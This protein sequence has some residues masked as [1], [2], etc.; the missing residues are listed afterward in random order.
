M[1]A[2]T[3]SRTLP[4]TIDEKRPADAPTV[5]GRPFAFALLS[6]LA[7][8]AC[9]AP[10]VEV[11]LPLGVVSFSPQDGASNVCP[12]WP[13][14]VCFNQPIDP[15]AMTNGDLLLGPASCAPRAAIDGGVVSGVS[16]SVAESDD[17]G[18]PICVTLTPSGGL[19]PGSCYALEAEGADVTQTPVV[20]ADGGDPLAVTV[21]SIF[22][23]GGPQSCFSADAG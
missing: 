11:S 8:F 20:S 16:A 17:A 14:T 12:H 22:Q 18:N 7:I 6:S 23:V 2:R 1:P 13:A 3:A 5:T 4:R 15:A 21:R 19:A 10:T 9:Q